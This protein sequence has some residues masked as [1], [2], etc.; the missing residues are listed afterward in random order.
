[1]SKSIH[2]M[3]A[4]N[5]SFIFWGIFKIFLN[6]VSLQAFGDNCKTGDDCAEGECCVNYVFVNW[7]GGRCQKM[8]QKGSFHLLNTSF[9]S[10]Q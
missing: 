7:F 6:S 3:C 2:C 5:N 9:L 4:F 10:N 1:M 8:R